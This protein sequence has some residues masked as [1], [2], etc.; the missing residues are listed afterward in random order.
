MIYTIAVD[1]PVGAGK[2]SVAGEVARRLGILHLDTG[3]MYRAF[4]LKALREGVSLDDEAALCELTQRCMP[5]VR[6]ENGEQHTYLD[7]ED[8]G[9]L[10][11]T[12]EI[13]MAASTVSKV[14]GVRKA[15]VAKQQ[16]MAKAQSMLMDGRDIGTVVLKNATLKIFLTASAEVRAKRRFDEMQ[17][18]GTP[19]TYEDVLAD[20]LRRDEQDTTREV[21][22]L[23]PAEDA[24]VLDT[25]QL[26]QEQAVEEIIGCLRLK[27]GKKHVRIEKKNPLYRFVCALARFLFRTIL[28]VRYHH[29]E[30]VQLDAPYILLA[31]HS[32]MMD[33]VIVFSPIYRYQVRFMA[34]KEL[35]QNC[36]LKWLFA[37]SGAIPVDRHNTDLAAVRAS[38]KALAQKQV[39]GIFPEGTRHKE[40]VMQDME[41]GIAV[42]ALRSGARLLPAYISG[43]LGLFRPVHV[44]FAPPVSVAEIAQKGV[45]KETCSEVMGLITDTYTALLKEHEETVR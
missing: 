24:Q 35:F 5:D 32:S 30:R 21:D 17:E 33:P 39:L 9:S 31:N 8:V 13:S 26:T 45:N 40:G 28:P 7:G 4:A 29:L 38:L 20:V 22:P 43:K 14:A 27:L 23:H 6:Y 11:R 3:A 18:K 1:G 2:S 15:M 42:I 10:I 37:Q 41:S 25:T 34:K 36:F 19:A 44:Y 16:A 12:P